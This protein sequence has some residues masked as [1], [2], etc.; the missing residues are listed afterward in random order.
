MQWFLVCSQSC[1]SV[2]TIYWVSQNIRL[3]FPNTWWKNLKKKQPHPHKSHFLSVNLPLLDI[4]CKRNCTLCSVS[5]L[6]TFTCHVTFPLV[7]LYPSLSNTCHTP[8]VY[9][10]SY[11][12]PYSSLTMKN[13]GGEKAVQP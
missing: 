6:V 13:F 3:D 5:R 2:T 10:R 9:S 1:A 8:S 12:S 7:R 4:S 11:L